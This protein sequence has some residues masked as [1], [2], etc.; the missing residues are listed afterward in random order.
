MSPRSNQRSRKPSTERLCARPLARQTPLM[1]PAD[2][3]AIT[4]TTT[5]VRSCSGLPPASSSSSAAYTR[6]LGEAEATA[7]FSDSSKAEPLTSRWSSFV[8]PCI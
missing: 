3:P 5:R 7:P 6:S 2:V 1:P 4:S 8:T